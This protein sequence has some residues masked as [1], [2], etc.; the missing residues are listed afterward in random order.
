M[1]SSQLYTSDFRNG[2][3]VFYGSTTT[4]SKETP[5]AKR[6]QLT[7]A[8]EIKF[9]TD[10]TLN[11]PICHKLI[12]DFHAIF[13]KAQSVARMEGGRLRLEDVLILN[14]RYRLAIRNAVDLIQ[15]EDENHTTREFIETLCAADTLWSLFEAIYMKPQG[16]SIVVDLLEWA[17]ES[18]EFA[19]EL[20]NTVLNTATSTGTAYDRHELYWNAIIAQVLVGDFTAAYNLLTGNSRFEKDVMM[21]RM[22][23]I[24]RSLKIDM[25][26][27]KNNLDDFVGIQK[28]VRELLSSGQ[29]KNSNDLAFICSILIGDK[30][31][32]KQIFEGLS[33]NWYELLPAY[34]LFCHPGADMGHVLQISKNLYNLLVIGKQPVKLDETIFTVLS[35]DYL[36]AIQLIC[37]TPSSL[38]FAAHLTDMIYKINND[39]VTGEDVDIRAT[40]LLDYA[41]TLFTVPQLWEIAVG[42]VLESGLENAMELLDTQVAELPIDN[43]KIANRLLHICQKYDLVRA[44]LDIT[45]AMT[46]KFERESEWSEA[47]CW[48]IRNETTELVTQVAHKVLL[49]ARPESI[50]QMAMF[51]Q[52]ADKFLLSPALIFLHKYYQFNQLTKRGY[53]QQAAQTLCDLIELGLAPP[54]F[55]TVLF[56]NMAK[57]L[58]ASNEG[59]DLNSLIDRATICDLMRRL[60]LFETQEMVRTQGIPENQILERTK[61][62][63]QITVLRRILIQSL[64]NRALA[65]TT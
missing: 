49:H 63:S 44:H 43:V 24:F 9:N 11:H 61:L 19:T 65:K 18:F 59:D 36:K 47:L 16:R 33:Q 35:L 45:K 50:S 54:E 4:S 23:K 25:L 42:Y 55:H 27:D 41:K 26:H 39:N 38:W 17:R 34:I 5:Q 13:T 1:A 6:S 46:L 51:E 62:N 30:T 15:A 31:A 56:E 7:N 48:A 52:L 29:F 12:Y 22:A 20:L 57:I 21:Q 60:T 53:L 10:S 58:N 40:L 3:V 32:F 37:N 8:V 64:A 28:H 14:R 2:S